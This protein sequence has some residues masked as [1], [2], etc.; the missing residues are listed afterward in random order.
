MRWLAGALAVVGA[1]LVPFVPIVSVVMF[2]CAIAVA[3][4]IEVRVDVDAEGVRVR[5][6]IGFPR[7]HFRRTRI[8]RATMIDVRP[9]KR[10]GWG[11]R[12]SLVLFRRAAWIV[13]A[14]PG[15]QLDLRDGRTFIVTVDAAGEAARALS[16]GDDVEPE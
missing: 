2:V 14:G 8:E 6:P 11:Y 3:L 16:G 12:G 5:G 1:V 10:G 9:M 13:R 7:V 15:L 4:F